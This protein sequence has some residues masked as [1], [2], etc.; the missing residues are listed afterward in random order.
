MTVEVPDTRPVVISK[1]LYRELDNL[2][3]FRHIV[4]HAYDYDLDGNRLTRIGDW[5]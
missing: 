4:R 5:G 1:M 3:A 2:R